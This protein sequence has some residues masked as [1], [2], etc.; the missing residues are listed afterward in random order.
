M[1]R[2]VPHTQDLGDPRPWST[3]VATMQ[4]QLA[5]L[6][7][8]APGYRQGAL[9]DATAEAAD[10]FIRQL[11]GHDARADALAA[12]WAVG[13]SS[14]ALSQ[15]MQAL[16]RLDIPRGQGADALRRRSELFESL[17]ASTVLLVALLWLV[18]TVYRERA[19]LP[20]A[21]TVG[22]AR[23]ED[24]MATTTIPVTF[25]AQRL[26]GGGAR[27]SV[28]LP[29]G[30]LGVVRVS[31]EI[32]AGM[33]S[34]AADAMRRANQIAFAPPDMH[35]SMGD[36]M[37]E[38]THP[39]DNPY[40]NLAAS[41]Y[42]GP[43]GPTLLRGAQD[44]TYQGVS[45]AQ[46]Q[47]AQQRGVHGDAMRP[48]IVPAPGL[49]VHGVPMR[50]VPTVLHGLDQSTG[51]VEGAPWEAGVMRP[52]APAVGPYQVPVPSPDALADRTPLILASAAALSRA[53]ELIA[54][55]EEEHEQ[56]RKLV[57]MTLHALD[58]YTGGMLGAPDTKEELDSI[59]RHGGGAFATKAAQHM[60]SMPE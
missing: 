28:E 54:Q 41:L 52:D 21:P 18:D 5:N 4:W 47:Y 16:R 53:L 2:R 48:I 17:P 43:M 14:W 51:H 23:R 55:H 11:Q 13:I 60:L 57:A 58:V 36:W 42:F 24:N 31:V 35:G 27:G 59:R 25:E 10:G 46:Q 12:V 15:S 32:P 26:R 56:L 19:G 3:I 37:R 22:D 1:T 8:L 30:A 33:L 34:A 44:L 9:D 49:V 6:G 7:A 45:A 40:A 50:H 39:A 29:L 38:L 20:P